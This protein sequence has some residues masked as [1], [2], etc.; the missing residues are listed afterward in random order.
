MSASALIAAIWN[1]LQWAHAFTVPLSGWR[2]GAFAAVLGALSALA[3]APFYVFPILAITL[4]GAVWSLDGAV[5][6]ARPLRAAAWRGWA[7]GFGYCL[8]GLYW[9][10]Y[11]FLVNPDT[12]LWLLP[13]AAVSFPGGLALFFSAAFWAAGFLWRGDWGRVLIFAFAVSATEWLRGHILTGFPWNL[14]GYTWAVSDATMQLASIVGIYGLTLLTLVAAAS[15]AALITATSARQ[16]QPYLSLSALALPVVL[17]GFGWMRLP[18]GAQP[19]IDD[20]KLRVVQPNVPQTEKWKPELALR[21]WQRLIEPLALNGGPAYTHAIWPEAAPPF[22]VSDHAEAMRMIGLSL[23]RGATLLTGSVFRVQRD[24]RTY[25]YNGMHAISDKGEVT[26]TYAKSH[27]VPFGE[28]LPF[29]D[30]MDWLGITKITGGRGGFSSGPG[31][32]SL[33]VSTVNS[34]GPQKTTL[35]P[36]ICY[37]IVFSGEV[38]DPGQRPDW[39]VNMTDDSW[40]GPSTGPYQHLGISRLRAVEEGL[41]VIRA[42]NTGISAIIDPYGRVVASLS[43]G[44]QGVLDGG[45]PRPLDSTGYAAW[46]SVLYTLAM[47]AL[48]VWIGWGRRRWSSDAGGPEA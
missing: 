2:A 18:P 6:Q 22:A 24:G 5:R 38:V 37:E 23:P 30:I 1:R 32:R 3:M 20:I 29:Q 48:A 34:A 46:G 35:G 45:V 21:N 7:F 10:G 41:S 42:A 47:A 14:F 13:F 43:L 4:S 19:E 44:T 25:A 31:V 36:L 16:A 9:V 33:T 15:P 26:A 27:L 28:Y 39:L 40:F 12:H 8:A 11:S 17:F